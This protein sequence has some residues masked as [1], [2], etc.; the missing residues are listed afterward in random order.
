[1]DLIDIEPDE[2]E[3]ELIK[4]FDLEALKAYAKEA[5]RQKKSSGKK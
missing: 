2:W 1:M 3:I 5:E 4:K